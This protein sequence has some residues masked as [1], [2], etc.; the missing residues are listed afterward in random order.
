[1]F[2]KLKLSVDVNRHVSHVTCKLG[3]VD[4][5]AGSVVIPHKSPNV[6]LI[7]IPYWGFNIPSSYLYLI[8]PH[9]NR[10]SNLWDMVQN[11]REHT[12]REKNTISGENST[13]YKC[14]KKKP[15]N[16]R[17]ILYPIFL[18]LHRQHIHTWPKFWL[19]WKLSFMNVIHAWAT[20][21]IFYGKLVHHRHGGCDLTIEA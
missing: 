7:Y 15:T 17:S 16:D 8:M 13:T 12:Y 11:G 6:T 19:S 10:A 21:C 14:T 9:C 4:F 18:W 20:K 5:F 1:M 2:L 3:N